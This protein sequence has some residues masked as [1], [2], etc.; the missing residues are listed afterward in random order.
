MNTDLSQR[1]PLAETVR[2]YER[3]TADIRQALELLKGA[4]DLLQE[5][6][7]T[8][9]SRHV[10]IGDRYNHVTFDNPDDVLDRVK[11][12]CW[13]ALIELSGVRGVMSIERSRQLDEQLKTGEGLPDLNEQAM[14]SMLQGM[15]GEVPT[16]AEEAIREIFEALRPHRSDYK[17]NSEFEIGKKVILEWGCEFAAFNPAHPWRINWHREQLFTAIG[18]VF[19]F[20]D[21]AG[22]AP[23]TH[24]GEIYDAVNGAG[25]D[26]R[27]ESTYF[28]VRC[29]RKGTIHLIFRRPDLVSKL[30]RI[31]GGARLKGAA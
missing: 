19:S 17:S 3:A 12:D 26:G 31:A 14:V 25:P 24:H 8:G 7:R 16:F 18:N 2:A 22:F 21:G 13:S 28:Q 1:M 9:G 20:L 5:A 23:R 29:F 4:D 27:G 10:T 30:N 6:F 15:Y 11:R